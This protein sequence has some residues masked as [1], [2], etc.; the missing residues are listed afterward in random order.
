MLEYDPLSPGLIEN[1]YDF[2]AELRETQPV[3]WHDRIESWVFTRY[4]ECSRILRDTTAFASDWRRAGYDMPEMDHPSLQVL[5][6]PEHGPVRHLFMNALHSQDLAGV[7]ALV[8]DESAAIFQ[9]FNSDEPFDFVAEVARPVVLQAVCRFL[10]VDTPETDSFVAL[11]DAV[12]RGMDAGF[13]PEA[14]PPAIA[15]RREID[16]LVESWV[17][18]ESTPGMLGHALRE[19][20]DLGVPEGYIWSTGRV[21]FLA[22]FSTTVSAAANALLALLD[23]PPLFERLRRDRGLLDSCIDELIRYDSPIQGTSRAC[24]ED[25][26]LGG[27]RIARGQTVLALI[28]SANRD[29]AQFSDPDAVVPDRRPNPHLAFGRGPHAC[30]GTLLARVVL[31]GLLAS[32]LDLPGTVRQAGPAYRGARATLRYPEQ[33]PITLNAWRD[34]THE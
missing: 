34:D 17:L 6:P 9:K 24:V 31:H 12:E 10:G 8:A 32:L 26:D 29:P 18:D 7:E 23:Q 22:G 1:P 2:Y 27:V 3:F 21:L 13:L 14:L 33:L 19:R 25:L 16:A 20:K 5:D 30:T 4:Q 15:A 28:G 11:T